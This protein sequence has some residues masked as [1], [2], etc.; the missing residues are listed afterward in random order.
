LSQEQRDYQRRTKRNDVIM[1]A[2]MAAVIILTVIIAFFRDN[3]L[4]PVCT[5]SQSVVVEQGDTLESIIRENVDG[6]NSVDIR[7]VVED[8][9]SHNRLT[10]TDV[11]TLQI[12]STIG[13]IPTGC[14]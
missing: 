10:E 13:G 6:I 1:Y 4:P 2:S 12:G 5:G 7:D 9:M 11:A 3:A 8:V 14:S